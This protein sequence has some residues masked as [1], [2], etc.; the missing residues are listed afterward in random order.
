MVWCVNFFVSFITARSI[1]LIKSFKFYYHFKRSKDILTLA[2]AVRRIDS[3]PGRTCTLH[4]PLFWLYILT[5]Q[6]IVLTQLPVR[7]D[8][9]LLIIAFL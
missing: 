6:C 5:P 4:L 9:L 1:I 2:A 3:T 8:P 7:V